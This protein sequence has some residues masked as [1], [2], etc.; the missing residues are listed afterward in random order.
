MRRRILHTAA[1][2]A[3]VIVLC[4]LPAAWILA[5]ADPPPVARFAAAPSLPPPTADLELTPSPAA[6]AP[7]RLYPRQVTLDVNGY[8]QWALITAAGDV[9]GSAQSA[10]ATSTTE[11]MIKAWLVADY[12]RRNPQPAPA[13]LTTAAR[14]I[15][16][17]DDQAAE[18]LYRA[19]GRTAVVD[20][21]ITMCGL[22]HTTPVPGWWSRTRMTAADAARLGRCVANGT[23]AGPTW[24]PWLLDRMREVRGEGRFG[25][26]DVDQGVAMKNGWTRYP[27]EGTW[28][29]NCLAIGDGWTLAVMLRYPLGEPLDYGARACAHVAGELA[30]PERPERADRHYPAG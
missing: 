3:A 11:S 24:T 13:A 21:L 19:G 20:R 12:L 8:G 6:P 25:I 17:S 18:T 1:A 26:V 10:T 7:V 9:A 28:H 29:V 23:A 27:G 16:D 15:V 14:A 5:G 2:L 4:G 30:E 22:T